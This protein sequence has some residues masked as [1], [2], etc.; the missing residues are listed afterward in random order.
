[1]R[2]SV[3][4]VSFSYP[5]GVEALRDV[6]LNLEPGEAVAIL[7][8]NGAGKST[9]A[10]HLNGLLRPSAGRVL[11]GDWGTAD[12]TTAQLAHRVGYVFQNPD[13]Q[14]FERVVRKE[15][16]FGPRNLGYADAEVGQLVAI[17]LEQVGLAQQ[18][19]AHPYDLP[20][21]ER[22]LLALAAV[23]AMQTPVIIFDE[24]TTGQDAAGVA[25]I[26]EII[27][28]LKRQGRTVITISHD[29]DFCAE[30]FPR[31]VLMAQAQIIADGPA[32]TLFSDAALLAQ[33]AVEPPQ[34]VRLAEGMGM[35]A[36]PLT[37][38]EFVD[39]LIAERVE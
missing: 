12:H 4:H 34:M 23:L 8:E 13:S 31:V 19:D 3:E 10:K 20:L 30:H 36:R 5:G 1:V 38:A 37:V 32:E 29:V 9:L 14:L 6:S 24:P 27:E 21:Y 11:I 7:G 25:R 35:V 33:A 18:A 28:D 39:S 22:K 2:V 16:A 26:G 17:A 15:V